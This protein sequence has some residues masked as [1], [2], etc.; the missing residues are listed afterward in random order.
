MSEEFETGFERARDHLGRA[1][2]EVLEAARALLDASLRASGL[3][4]VSPD[5]LAG[6]IGR[7]LDALVASLRDG[8]PF[9]LPISLTDPLVGALEAEIARWE[10]RSQTDAAS[11]P[12]LRA[13]LGLRELLFELGVRSPTEPGSAQAP[14][15]RNSEPSPSGRSAKN[16]VQR[17]DVED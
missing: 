8:K 5:S 10:Q 17:F 1:A 14:R 3:H 2:L 4:S 7:S 9:P 6:E 12:V 16:R 11:R 15:T 13:F